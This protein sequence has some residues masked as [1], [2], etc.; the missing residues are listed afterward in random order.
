[1]QPAEDLPVRVGADEHGDVRAAELNSGQ[2]QVLVPDRVDVPVGGTEPVRQGRG[3][4]RVPGGEE[5]PGGQ[6]R[7]EP[8]GGAD[9]V[10]V[11]DLHGV[12]PFTRSAPRRGYA[13]FQS[14]VNTSVAG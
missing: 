4:V 13:G 11:A 7:P 10:L 3:A 6:P 8:A 9:E 12:L 14:P 2:Q 1:D 5:Q